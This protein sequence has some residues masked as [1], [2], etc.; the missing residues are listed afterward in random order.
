MKLIAPLLAIACLVA[1]A[2]RAHANT[3]E[4]KQGMVVT[5]HPIA[6][7]V[8]VKVLSEGGNAVDAAVAAA[9]MLGVVDGHNSGIGGGCFM[10]IRTADGKTAALDGREMAPAA[11]TR[12]MFVRDGKGDTSLSQT[13][14]LASGIPGS[15]AVY[16]Y[17]TKNFGKKPLRELIT[18]AA[19]VAERGFAIDSRYA[20]KLRGSARDIARFPESARILLKSDGTPLADGDT[21]RQGD[22]ART[23]RGIAD[24]GGDY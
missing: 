12:D 22:L 2:A 23:Y 4:S 21:L 19:D 16:Q 3:A 14:P 7:D 18:P 24:Q 9:L 15:V 20:T 11:A 8:G 1:V 5:V 17:A 6:T 13:G 10:L